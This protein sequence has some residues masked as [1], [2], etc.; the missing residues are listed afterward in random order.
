[1]PK[2][3]R[4]IGRIAVKTDK[5]AAKIAAM[6]ARTVIAMV[7]KKVVKTLVRDAVIT[8]KETATTDAPVAKIHS[9]KDKHIA[10]DSCRVTEMVTIATTVA[11][12]G[13]TMAFCAKA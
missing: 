1:M 10:Q 8:R 2:C 11:A 3:F 12:I 4:R 13:T 9:A 7:W 5:N 6:R